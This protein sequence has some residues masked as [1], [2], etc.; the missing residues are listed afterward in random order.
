MSGAVLI[1]VAKLTA[2]RQRVWVERDLN[3]GDLRTLSD[4]RHG[5]A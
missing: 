3:L 4:R 1:I 2:H 5:E